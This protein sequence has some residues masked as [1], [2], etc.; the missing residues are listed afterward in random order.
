MMAVGVA[1]PNAHGQAMTNTDQ[2][3]DSVCGAL[4]VTGE[5]DGLDAS[6]RESLDR[7]LCP[8]LHFV[9]NRDDPEQ[10]SARA[11]GSDPHHR[12]SLFF[13][14]H[15]TTFVVRSLDFGLVHEVAVAD[16]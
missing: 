10:L 8:S 3:G 1:K 14:R 11:F 4:I 7:G 6:L 2:A 13:E 5:H 9:S 12:A 15:R 16:D